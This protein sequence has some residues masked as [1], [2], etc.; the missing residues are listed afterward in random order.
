MT[1]TGPCSAGRRRGTSR[2]VRQRCG[3]GAALSLGVDL[4]QRARMDLAA[5]RAAVDGYRRPTGHAQQELAG[6]LGLHPKVLSHK[7]HG[8]DGAALR[9][10]EVRGVVR[11][12]AAWHAL[13]TRAEAVKLLA[14]MDLGPNSFSPAEW[15]APP[16]A[17]LD[18]GGDRL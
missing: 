11:A 5:F 1:L 16:L 17:G 13:Q 14:L 15:G 7:L 2:K 6:A 9:H 3:E 4:A 18:P 10:D 12:L 8:N